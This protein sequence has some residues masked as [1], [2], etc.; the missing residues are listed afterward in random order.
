MELDIIE[1]IKDPG[2]YI[3]E[4][5]SEDFYLVFIP[6]IVN[7]EISWLTVDEIYRIYNYEIV[8]NISLKEF[9]PFQSGLRVYNIK[10]A[11]S[12]NKIYERVVKNNNIDIKNHLTPIGLSCDYATLLKKLLDAKDSKSIYDYTEIIYRF[13][14]EFFTKNKYNTRFR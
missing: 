12:L 9:M 2:Y 8:K 5:I 13:F 14:F 3:I 1:K 11:V 6:Q 7:K 4:T 10:D